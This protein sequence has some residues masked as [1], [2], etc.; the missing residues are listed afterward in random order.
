M[1]RAACLTVNVCSLIFTT[2]SYSVVLWSEPGTSSTAYHGEIEPLKTVLFALRALLWAREH[3]DRRFLSVS[4]IL[5]VLD[6]LRRAKFCRGLLWLTF[7][8]QYRQCSHSHCS[9][10]VCFRFC[11][12]FCETLFGL[13]PVRAKM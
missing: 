13:S 12:S 7:H 2:T 5:F 10:I 4:Q 3:Y 11:Q 6:M 9:L 8:L 1:F